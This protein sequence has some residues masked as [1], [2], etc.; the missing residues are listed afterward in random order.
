M[1]GQN[2]VQGMGVPEW[3]GQLIRKDPMLRNGSQGGIC[4]SFLN[5]TCLPIEHD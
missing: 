3:E 5:G 1:K 4:P 2:Q